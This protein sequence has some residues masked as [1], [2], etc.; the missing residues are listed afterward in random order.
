MATIKF[1]YR[2]TKDRGPLSFKFLHSHKGKN[3]QYWV[4]TKVEVSKYY[5]ENYHTKSEIE[6]YD[7]EHFQLET[8]SELN[9]IKKHILKEFTNKPDQTSLSKAWIETE[10]SQY[11]FNSN[12][13][14][15]KAL[16]EYIEFYL[17]VRSDNLKDSTKKKYRVLKNKIIRYEEKRNQTVLIKNIGERFK[18][19]FEKYQ[20]ENKYAQNTI[21]RDIGLIKT[22]CKH[23]RK[24]G[25]ET[26]PQLDFLKVEQEEVDVI[27]LNDSE[28]DS[29]REMKNLSNDMQTT[30]DWL[31]LSCNLGQRVSDF[32]EFD[33]SKTWWEDGFGYMNFIQQKTD[34]RMTIPL[35]Q[36]V[37]NI[38]KR[39]NNN[40]PKKM[41]HTKYN[42]NLKELCK[43][44][45]IN[46]KIP[47]RVLQKV[48]GVEGYRRV[49]GEYEKYNL[50]S[51]H[52]GRRS[53]ATNYY[54]K[55]KTSYIISITGHTTEKM[56]RNYLPKSMNYARE[57]HEQMAM[58]KK[59][60]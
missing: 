42:K 9:K 18:D 33:F 48:E 15:P 40:F 38:L 53:F 4:K 41:Q 20:K 17:K 23:A 24:Y 5:W 39:N 22:Y 2:S 50:I 60:A 55:I 27:Y 10:I 28:L 45:G 43:I 47:G 52:V 7:M 44:A 35:F 31:L 57:I 11:Y 8:K 29:I 26:H 13:Y 46:K 49:K 21:H 34:K 16:T 25:L 56:Y 32:M 14:I 30:K 3:F 36:E 59:T 12:D 6:N 58:L 1:Y 19:D 51:S 54:G 37:V